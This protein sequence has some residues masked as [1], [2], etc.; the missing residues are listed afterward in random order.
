VCSDLSIE[1]YIPTQ[2]GVRFDALD[3]VYNFA[4]LVGGVHACTV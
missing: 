2:R 4:E 1:S 3:M